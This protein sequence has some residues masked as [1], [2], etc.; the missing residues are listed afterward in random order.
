MNVMKLLVATI[1]GLGSFLVCGHSASAEWFADLYAGPTFSLSRD[2]KSDGAAGR[3]TLHDV[4][5]DTAASGG[6]RVGR[7][8]EALPFLG[9]AVDVLQFY[10]NIAPQTV[11]LDGCFAR[12]GCGSRQGGTGSFDI[13]TTAPSFDLM[14]RLP[15]M[16][17]PDAP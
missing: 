13:P 15:L 11:Q 4:H 10:P 5:F 7:Y 8:F 9:L 2:V 6:V 14:L 17:T 3:G 12:I 16:K 1:I